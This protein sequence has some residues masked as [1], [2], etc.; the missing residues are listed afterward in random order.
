MSLVMC[1]LKLLPIV[2]LGCFPIIQFLEFIIYSGY[3][4]FARY[5][6]LQIPPPIPVLCFYFLNY[7]FQRTKGFNFD[8][9]KLMN[10]FFNGSWFS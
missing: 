9:V 2:L 5:I 4:S 6:V 7:V 8:E 10:H 1:L 3:K